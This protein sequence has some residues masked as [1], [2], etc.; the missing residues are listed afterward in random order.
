M[1]GE[2]R[3]IHGRS[4]LALGIIPACAGNTSQR[5]HPKARSR[6]HPRVRGEH[7]VKNKPDG[8]SQGSSPRARGTH[9]HIERK[10]NNVG[11]IPA[12]AGNTVFPNIGGFC[13]R[14]HPRVRGEHDVPCPPATVRQGS[15]PRARGTPTPPMIPP[16]SQWDHPRVRGE[17]AC[18]TDAS[19]L[20]SGSS[21]RARGTHQGLR[22]FDSG[23]G[24]IP[25]C[26]GN[27]HRFRR[28][29][30]NA[31][32]HPRV[33]GEHSSDAWKGYLDT[34]SSP[35]ARGTLA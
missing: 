21:P 30:S 32:D 25:A 19:Y 10:R 15:S 28:Y 11:I 16:F 7:T 29:S 13:Y 26:A 35:R 2:H 27:T 8:T 34:G 3:R 18:L 20:M 14:D 1:R 9:K 33:R 6:D 22:R 31:R 4:R 17:H 12:C 23:I 5:S 24:I